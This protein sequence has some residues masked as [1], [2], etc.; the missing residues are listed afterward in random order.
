MKTFVFFSKNRG[1]KVVSQSSSNEFFNGLLLGCYMEGTTW[2][3]TSAR[4]GFRIVKNSENLIISRNDQGSPSSGAAISSFKDALRVNGINNTI[5]IG[6]DYMTTSTPNRMMCFDSSNNITNIPF[7]QWTGS[8][9]ITQSS[10]SRTF[11]FSATRQGNV[12]TLSCNMTA[13]DTNVWNI[14]GPV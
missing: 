3:T 7:S 2:K 12:Y 13:S 14:V 4:V 11:L 8:Q 5:S 6:N 9:T 10:V 1:S